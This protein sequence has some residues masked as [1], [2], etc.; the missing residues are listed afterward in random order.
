MKFR[1]DVGRGVGRLDSGRA[2]MIVVKIPGDEFAFGSDSAFDLDNA[3][4]AEVSPSEFFLASPNNLDGTAG[5]AGETGSL[6]SG[7]AGVLAAVGGARVGDD[8][9]HACFGNAE[10]ASEFAANSKGTL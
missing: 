9:A 1:A 7:V 6:D 10:S 5:S 2:G 4:R 3:G 8:D